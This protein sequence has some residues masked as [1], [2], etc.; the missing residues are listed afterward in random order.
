MP[1]PLFTPPSDVSHKYVKWDAQ[2]HPRH[3]SKSIKDTYRIGEK[4]M[5]KDRE[6]LQTGMSA[7]YLTSTGGSKQYPSPRMVCR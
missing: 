5:K 1:P 2:W 7:Y 6:F 3:L 4:D